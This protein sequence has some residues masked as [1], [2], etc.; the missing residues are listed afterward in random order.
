MEQDRLAHKRT[1]VVRFGR[2][3][4][5]GLYAA[6]ALAAALVPVAVWMAT[7]QH[8]GALL[9]APVPLLLAGPLRTF[10]TTDRPARLN[11]LLGKT[12]LVLLVYSAVLAAGWMLG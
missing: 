6:C 10:Q 9:A 1:L 5:V 3:L 12:A 2:A 11:P 7:D 4:G 8:A